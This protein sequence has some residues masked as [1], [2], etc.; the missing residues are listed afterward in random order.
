VAIDQAKLR[1][2]I[3]TT[4]N[5][6]YRTLVKPILIATAATLFAKYAGK[7]AAWLGKQATAPAPES[8]V[9]PATAIQP[10]ADSA[11]KLETDHE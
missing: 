7:A 6:I 10:A 8:Q 3:R 5:E 4:A 1:K 9:E 11:P 2:E